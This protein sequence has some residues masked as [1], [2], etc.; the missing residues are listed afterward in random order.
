MRFLYLIGEKGRHVLTFRHLS[1]PEF[2]KTFVTTT[3]I[4]KINYYIG[5]SL[6]GVLKRNFL[7]K[8]NQP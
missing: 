3:K 4:M 1:L 5:K 6:W 8:E 2:T 7:V